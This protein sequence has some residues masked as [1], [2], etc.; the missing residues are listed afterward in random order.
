[1]S[2][3][4]IKKMGVKHTAIL[5]YLVANPTATG[6]ETARAFGITQSW[7]SIIKNSHAFQDQLR[8]RQDEFFGEVVVPLREKLVGVADIAV[9]RLAVKLETMNTAETIETADKLLHRLGYAPN[10]KGT[11]SPAGQPLVQQ[12]NFYNVDKSALAA[13]RE[14]FGKGVTI[15]QEAA[16]ALVQI[17]AEE[18][19]GEADELFAA[20]SEV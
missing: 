4:Q 11:G 19:A 12:N 5:D 1:M 3:T 13:A 14:N 18:S 17:E 2:E 9:D 8:L 7:L 6:A 15:D 16:G 10:V 20:P